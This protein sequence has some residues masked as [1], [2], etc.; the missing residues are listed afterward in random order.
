MPDIDAVGGEDLVG[1]RDDLLDRRGP[2][3]GLT[4]LGDGAEVDVHAEQVPALAGDQQDAAAG[5]GLDRALQADVGEVGAGE[6]IHDAPG[7]VRLVALQLA[8][9]GPAHAGAGAVTADD[10]AGAD[11]SLGAGVRIVVAGAPQ[12]NLDRVVGGVGIVGDGE[13]DELPPVVRAHPGRGVVHELGEV[14]EDAG[15]VDDEV[16]KFG[17]A[18]LVVDGAVGAVDVVGVG[19]V[20]FPERHLG[21]PVRLVGD[22]TGEAE[23]LEGL[24]AP[25]LDAV[26]LAD[27]EAVRAAVDDPGGQVREH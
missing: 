2:D 26:G 10:V 8:A 11:G 25:R 20:G 3:G 27:L 24:D 19:G 15:L 5:A 16:G 9:D 13:V 14:V 4:F 7:V 1:L 6:H 22:L 18:D 17:D 12:P 21:D 23:R